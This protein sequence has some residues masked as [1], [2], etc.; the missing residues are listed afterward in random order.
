MNWQNI[1][2]TVDGTNEG[3][4]WGGDGPE[5]KED[6]RQRTERE[7]G[8]YEN[9]MFVSHKLGS[10]IHSLQKLLDGKDDNYSRIELEHILNIANEKK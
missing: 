8:N 2:K 1:I 7:E 10:V 4:E 3:M 6:D 5:P 9:Y